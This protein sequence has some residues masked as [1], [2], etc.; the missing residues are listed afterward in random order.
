MRG[1]LPSLTGEIGLAITSLSRRGSWTSDEPPMVIGV[2]ISD[3]AAAETFVSGHARGRR[4][5]GVRRRHDLSRPT[6]PTVGVTD[7]LGPHLAR[8]STRSRPPSTCWPARAQPGRRPRASRP[9]SRASRPAISRAVYLDLQSLGAAHRGEHGAGRRRGLRHAHGVEA[10]SPSCPRTWSP[11][12]RPRRT[13]SRSRP[14][15]RR[16]RPCRGPAGRRV[17]PRQPLPGRHAALRRD[18]RP[19][20][21]ARRRP[22][23]G[24]AAMDERRVRRRDGARRGH[25][26]RPAARVPRLRRRC[27]VGAG[28]TCGRALAGHRRGGH[29]R[30]CG[31]PSAA[32]LLGILSFAR[33]ERRGGHQRRRA[34]RSATPR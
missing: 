7:E 29:R 8:R 27:R 9:P 20:R 2:G 22:G 12:S 33:G 34:R 25:A 21:D 19:R 16:P 30:G 5:R 4:D 24:L 14:S 32:A 3:R 17:G 10:S 26:R 23:T 18:A 6:T 1:L 28:L 15:S 11:T 31:Q 13:D